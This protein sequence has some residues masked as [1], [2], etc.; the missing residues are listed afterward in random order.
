MVTRAYYSDDEGRT[1]G[2]F[3]TSVSSCTT[4]N[5]RDNF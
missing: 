3:R 1:P 4:S 5:A 2:R